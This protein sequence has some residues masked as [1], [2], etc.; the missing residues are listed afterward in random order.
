MQHERRRDP[1]PWSWEIPAAI[2]ISVTL[3][4]LLG[5]QAGRSLANLAVGAGWTWPAADTGLV[6]TPFGSAFWNSLPGVL[7][8]DS[9]AGLPEPSPTGLAGPA[10]LWTCLGLTEILLL[11]LTVWTGFRLYLRWGPGRMCGMASAGEAENLLGV[12]RLRK[13]AALVRPDLHSKHGEQAA[14][15]H[16]LVTRQE[17]GEL[18]SSQIGRGLSSPWL[19]RSGR[20]V[21]GKPADRKP[22]DESAI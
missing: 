1:Y 12:T 16:R 14:V 21:R 3:V 11:A 4:V 18:Q 15:V 5:I 10:L 13:V 17:V 9:Q 19:R 2:G 7:A 8:G 20:G 22:R 6:A